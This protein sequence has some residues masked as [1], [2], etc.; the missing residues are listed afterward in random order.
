MNVLVCG[1]RDYRNRDI[2]FG[3]LNELLSEHDRLTIIDGGCD[4]TDSWRGGADRW[5]REWVKEAPDSATGITV[6]AD[7]RS[8]GRRAGSIRNAKMIEMYRPDLVLA[9]SGGRGTEDMKRRARAAGIPVRE[10]EDSL[11]VQ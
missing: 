1:G 4:E 6:H 8:L 10:I 3:V 9:F 2:V 11:N 7:W 5:A